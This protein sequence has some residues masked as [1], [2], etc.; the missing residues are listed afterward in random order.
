VGIGTGDIVLTTAPGAP[1]PPNGPDLTVPRMRLLG[2]RVD[3]SHGPGPTPMSVPGSDRRPR[4]LSRLLPLPY[5]TPDRRNLSGCP[6]PSGPGPSALFLRFVETAFYDVRQKVSK[7][8][9]FGGC[10]TLPVPPKVS[11]ETGCSAYHPPP[12]RSPVL[13]FDGKVAPPLPLFALIHERPRRGILG[14]C[15]APHTPPYYACWA[16]RRGR[17]APP[18]WRGGAHYGRRRAPP[19]RLG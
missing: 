13:F 10:V 16:T 12:S 17:R 9:S 4:V 6:V 15:A 8:H 7:D 11:N 5:N 2:S 14:S 1:Y 3:G 18:P 19:R